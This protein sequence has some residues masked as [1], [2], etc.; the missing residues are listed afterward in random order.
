MSL[1]SVVTLK[2]PNL[3]V[4]LCKSRDAG[5]RLQS[6]IKH[7]LYSVPCSSVFQAPY[8]AKSGIQLWDRSY[9]YFMSHIITL[10]SC[11]NLNICRPKTRQCPCNISFQ[12][13]WIYFQNHVASRTTEYFYNSV[14][15]CYVLRKHVN[16][17]NVACVIS[18]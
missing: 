17:Y 6:D 11:A 3:H 8:L 4:K 13:E 18:A 1:N 16:R 7:I 14:N 12:E 10:W 5:R 9:Q 15:V 2:S